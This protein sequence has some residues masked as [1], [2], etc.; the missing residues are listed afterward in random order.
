MLLYTK[1]YSINQWYRRRMTMIK[2]FIKLSFIFCSIIFYNKL[3]LS[4]DSLVLAVREENIEVIQKLLNSG[5]NPDSPNRYGEVALRSAAR[6]CYIEGMQALLD[7]KANPNVFTNNIKNTPLM[8]AAFNGCIEAMELLLSKGIKPDHKNNDGSTAFT[9]A[10]I[11]GH[12][13]A[14]ELLVN[15]G[16]DINSPDRRGNTPFMLAANL[17]NVEMMQTLL[18]HKANPLSI[19]ANNENALWRAAR[20][21]HVGAVNFLLDINFNINAPNK[22]GKTPLIAAAE[23]RAIALQYEGFGIVIGH[24]PPESPSE[25]YIEIIDSLLNAG[26]NASVIDQ[27]NLTALI[28]VA[29]ENDI[30]AVRLLL[31]YDKNPDYTNLLGYSALIVASLN[32]HVEMVELIK[33]AIDRMQK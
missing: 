31:T 23:A 33:E 24:G 19:N 22:D 5:V 15:A 16:G 26:A 30:E 7:A 28:Y 4:N 3:V 27:H 8:A 13:S 29:F 18:T 9:S 25:N 17:G 32:G 11:K 6:N 2:P 1:G 14:V 10:I 20:D 21:G 12:T